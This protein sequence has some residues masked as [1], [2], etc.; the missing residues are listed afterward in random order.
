MSKKAAPGGTGTP[1]NE[2]SAIADKISTFN[3]LSTQLHPYHGSQPTK[4]F[5]VQDKSGTALVNFAVTEIYYESMTAWLENAA[6]WVK[7]MMDVLQRGTRTSTERRSVRALAEC[8]RMVSTVLTQPLNDEWETAYMAVSRIVDL[9]SGQEKRAAE[10]K[11]R[12]ERRAAKGAKAAKRQVSDSFDDG[13]LGHGMLGEGMSG[14][15][16][17]GGVIGGDVNA[18]PDGDAE[19]MDKIANWDL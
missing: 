15:G 7:E 12:A 9:E 4:T 1:V 16:M 19:F 3:R 8:V 5:G 14:E 10:D 13:I 18:E 17:S 6:T 11:A 2:L